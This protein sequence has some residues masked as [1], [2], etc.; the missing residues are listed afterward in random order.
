MPPARGRCTTCSCPSRCGTASRRHRRCSWSSTRSS[1]NYPWEL[2]SAPT[3]SGRTALATQGAVIRQFS[4]TADASGRRRAGEQGHGARDRRRQRARPAR[5]CPAR[6]ARR[7]RSATCSPPTAP[8]ASLTTYLDDGGEE[9]S[10]VDLVNALDG[11]HQILHIASHG[12]YVDGD[13]AATGALL[14]QRVPPARR[15][16]PPVAPR[17]R[18]GV[19]QLL[20]ARAHRHRPTRRRSRP[21]VHGDRRQSRDRR[22]LAG[23]RRRRP[24]VRQLVLPSPARRCPLRRCRRRRHAT[25]ASPPAGAR[26]GRPTS[27]TAIPSWCST[28]R[29]AGHRRRGRP[30]ERRR[31]VAPVEGTRGAGLRPRPARSGATRPSPRRSS[32][33]RTT[34]MRHGRSRTASSPRPCQSSDEQ[35]A[36]TTVQRQLA[37]V[38]AE[39]GQFRAAA[40]RYLSIVA[41]PAEIVGLGARPALDER[42]G[43]AAGVELPLAGRAARGAG[44]RRRRSIAASWW[45]TSNTPSPSPAP[46][47]TSP[48]RAESYGILGGALKRLATI[49]PDGRDELIR[50]AADAYER[51]PACAGHRLR[52]RRS[53]PTTGPTRDHR[54]PARAAPRPVATRTRP[55]G[56]EAGNR[57]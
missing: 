27:A 32:S 40:Q 23:R 36:A 18:P 51:R 26:P 44:E 24:G 11:D 22:R 15:D 31:P 48:A 33:P 49:A 37:R 50:Q 53:R 46:P 52:R 2:L 55:N 38:A 8:T 45:A 9:L 35:R 14:N 54:R 47:C 12:E 17:S 19:P 21:R 57:S 28:A 43:S 20:H 56:G 29:R 39:L 10:T 4:E 25:P 30:G 13:P 42:R 7:A 3:P 5:R 16:G 6:C 34:A 41:P 1:A